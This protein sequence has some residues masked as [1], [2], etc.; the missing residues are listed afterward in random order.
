[1][2]ILLPLA[3]LSACSDDAGISAELA[4]RDAEIAKV[5]DRSTALENRV[6]QLETKV[7]LNRIDA[8]SAQRAATRNQNDHRSDYKSKW[9]DDMITDKRLRDLEFESRYGR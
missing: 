1:M 4:K 5:M 2:I 9:V 8:A 3:M 7:E 6:K